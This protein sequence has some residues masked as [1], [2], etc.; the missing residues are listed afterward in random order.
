[1]PKGKGTY[2]SKVGR[3]KK[4]VKGYQTGGKVMNYQKGGIVDM[5]NPMMPDDMQ[6][7]AA[8]GVVNAMDRSQNIQGYAEGGKVKS[9]SP[10]AKMR[11][12]LKKKNELRKAENKKFEQA[13]K[14]LHTKGGKK[15]KSAVADTTK[16]KKKNLFK[17]DLFDEFE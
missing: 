2:G 10:L 13:R 11:A 9:D 6:G 15:K 7:F 14:T 16:K 3:P 17:S 5:K 12:E 8:G 1:M 4:K